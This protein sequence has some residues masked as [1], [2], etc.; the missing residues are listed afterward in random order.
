[1]KKIIATLLAALFMLTG[2]LASEVTEIG[3]Q[4]FIDAKQTLALFAAGDYETAA[5]ILGFADAPELE[6]F[7]AGNF[8]TLNMGVQ[9]RVS[10]AYYTGKTWKLA[11]P[12]QEPASSDIETMILISSDG[13]SFIGYQY[14]QWG[15]VE[16]E[17]RYC[18]YVI[19]NEEYV[20]ATPYILE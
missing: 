15:E 8:A 4:Q 11:V 6:R 10:V 18:D 3:A 14:A 9:T 16:A 17:F 19:W 5:A 13:I 2:A 7:A 12:L 1:M 20:S